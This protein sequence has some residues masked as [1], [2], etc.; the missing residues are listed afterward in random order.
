M[1][2]F[3]IPAL[4]VSKNAVSYRLSRNTSNNTLQSRCKECNKSD[5]MAANASQEHDDVHNP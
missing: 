2:F 4:T 1:H 3:S 5:G